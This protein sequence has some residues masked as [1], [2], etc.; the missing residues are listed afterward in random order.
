MV[1]AVECES[2][3]ATVKCIHAISENP[4]RSPGYFDIFDQVL[5]V[6]DRSLER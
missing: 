5:D 3:L 6:N 4:V 1:V 2:D